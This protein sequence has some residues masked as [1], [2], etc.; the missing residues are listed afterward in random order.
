MTLFGRTRADD[1]ALAARYK[2]LFSVTKAMA[3]ERDLRK[4]LA[5]AMD[6]IIEITGAERGFV[7]LGG[8][9][10]GQV[11]VARNLDKEHVKQPTGK[12]SRSILRRAME[13]KETVLTDNATEDKNFLGSASIGE[14]KLRSVLCSPLLLRDSA[15]GA[16]YVDHRFREGEF[17]GEEM[18]LLNEFRDIAA[19]A[20]ENARLFEENESQRKRLEELNTALSRD[21]AKQN[22]EMEAYRER[23]R[24]LPQREDYKHDYSEI[25]G[26]SPAIREI[27]SVLDRVIPTHFPVLIQ[28]ESGTGKELIAR[29][30]HRNGPRASKAF[31]S[32]NCGA[33]PEGLL[34]SELF[35][36]V[37]GSFTGAERTR[38]GLFQRAHGG[39]LFLDEIGE[40][41]PGMQTK[42]LRAVQEGEVRKVGS[43]QVDRVD[44]RIISATNRDLKSDVEAG[45]FREDLFYRMNVVAIRLPPLRERREDIETLLDHFLRK[46]CEEAKTPQKQFSAA[47]LRILTSYSWP[48][49][50][51]E[52]QNEV[53]R[54]VA[55]SDAV[56]G[57]ELLQHLKDGGA[58]G[59]G[60]G[61]QKGSLAGHTLRDLERQAILETLRMTGGNKAETAKRLGI[62]RR[63]LYDKLSKFTST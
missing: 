19:V 62:S 28:G 12:V 25:L 10:D 60:G 20:I 30:I 61:V 31:L 27:F 33:L 55:L 24:A 1:A 43:T 58:A 41:S 63:A 2:R 35:G 9:E 36:H 23:R 53:K 49:N 45:R 44:V 42:L 7:W 54:L 32:E 11:A 48:G 8:P 16:I 17:R 59:A 38:D 6:A 37:K 5:T 26:N 22:E 29:A 14:M 13:S 18:A 40:M 39:T 4:V 57:P 50:I 3:S 34:E 46:C 51:R 15:I 52:L 21:W 47:A 56:I